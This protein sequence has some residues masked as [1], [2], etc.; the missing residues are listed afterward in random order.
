MEHDG[1]PVL[2]DLF[3]TQAASTFPCRPAAA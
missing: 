2:I 3:L 1:N